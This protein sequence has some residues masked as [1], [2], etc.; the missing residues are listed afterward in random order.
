MRSI[1]AFKIILD[2]THV[3][4]KKYFLSALNI[5]YIY[6]NKKVQ[7]KR[8]KNTEYS[9]VTLI[10]KLKANFYHRQGLIEVLSDKKHCAK[11]H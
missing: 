9:W 6:V 10:K 2:L 4:E 3:L 1:L 8:T 7:K 5:S 11:R